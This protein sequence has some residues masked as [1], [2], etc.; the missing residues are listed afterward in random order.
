MI[1]EKVQSKNKIEQLKYILIGFG[2]NY[3]LLT[4]GEKRQ[5]LN[6][7]LTYNNCKNFSIN[8]FNKYICKAKKEYPNEIYECFNEQSFIAYCQLR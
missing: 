7:D 4:V 8:N 1:K 5:L 2:I 6:M 3:N